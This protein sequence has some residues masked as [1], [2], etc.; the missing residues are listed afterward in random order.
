M[1]LRQH[2]AR[3]ESISKQQAAARKSSVEKMKNELDMKHQKATEMRDY[4][5]EKVK[6]I[7][8][9]S[10]EKKK[11]SS[12]NSYIAH[13]NMTLPVHSENQPPVEKQ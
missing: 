6:S 10:A 1:K 12:G 9:K 4:Q 3:V 11:P 7:A 5:L 2:L 13:E 8:Q